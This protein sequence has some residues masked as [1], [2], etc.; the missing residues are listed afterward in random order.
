MGGGGGGGGWQGF[1]HFDFKVYHYLRV[2][3]CFWT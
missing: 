1:G 2:F 3:G